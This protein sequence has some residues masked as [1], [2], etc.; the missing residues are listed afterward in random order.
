MKNSFLYQLQLKGNF[1]ALARSLKRSDLSLDKKRELKKGVAG[2]VLV[3]Y[4][5][6]ESTKF[7]VTDFIKVSKKHRS[8][9]VTF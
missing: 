9:V 5:N 8:N 1:D 7:E 3:V 4:L 6:K 2:L